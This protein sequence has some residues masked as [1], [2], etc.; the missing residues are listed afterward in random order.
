MLLAS[1]HTV[2]VINRGLLPSLLKECQLFGVNHGSR[3]QGAEITRFLVAGSLDL[4]MRSFLHASRDLGGT[5][6]LCP[7]LAS[8]AHAGQEWGG[9]TGRENRLDF[10]G[11]IWRPPC[12]PQ[13]LIGMSGQCAERCPPVPVLMHSGR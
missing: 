3:N 12:R 1:V 6:G 9:A 4:V 10:L 7:A 13:C 2:L 8:Q 11:A 5:L